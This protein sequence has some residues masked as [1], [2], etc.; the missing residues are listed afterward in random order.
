MPA[1]NLLIN[2][3]WHSP[4]GVKVNQSTAHLFLSFCLRVVRP[5]VADLHNGYSGFHLGDFGMEVGAPAHD[6]GDDVIVKYTI[7]VY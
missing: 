2:G 3:S 1:A 5:S 6:E 4:S 7:Y